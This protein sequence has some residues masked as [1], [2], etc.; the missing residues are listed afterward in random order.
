MNDIL[1]LFL[2]AIGIAIILTFVQR[3]FF[4]KIETKTVTHTVVDTTLVDSLYSVIEYLEDIPDVERDTVIKYVEIP[5]PI[6]RD[7]QRIYRTGLSD[8]LINIGVESTIYEN[9]LISQQIEYML[10]QRIVR[11]SKLELTYHIDTI[12][13]ITTTRTI[14]NSF[15]SAGAIINQ[16]SIIPAIT[17]TSRN[18]ITFLFGY[19]VLNDN[20][21]GGILIPLF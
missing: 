9:S 17:Y 15:I 10:K 6:E 5:A 14:H 12:T 2:Y 3:Q 18:N 7:N 21:S 19:D 1:K 8:N 16:E 13:Q 11:E 20:I 4:P